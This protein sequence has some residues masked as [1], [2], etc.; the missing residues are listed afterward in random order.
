MVTMEQV[1]AL[2][3]QVVWAFS[4]ASGARSVHGPPMQP[5]CEVLLGNDAQGLLLGHSVSVCRQLGSLLLRE[6]ANLH[7]AE[8]GKSDT[9]CN[10]LP[11]GN[12]VTLLF[13]FL[14]WLAKNVQ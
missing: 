6:V 3:E 10:V 4:G 12:H 9:G 13:F 8:L 1:R 7:F 11:K 14:C 5:G 2:A